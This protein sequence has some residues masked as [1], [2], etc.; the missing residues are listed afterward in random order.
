MEKSFF[1]IAVTAAF[2][3][4]VAMGCGS[5]KQGV[6]SAGN[7]QTV[8]KSGGSPF[9]EVY[10]APCA[11]FDTDDEFAATGIASGSKNRMDV[12]QTSAITN[13]QNVI[14]QKVQHAYKG[15]I[16]DYSNYMGA[17]AGSDAEVKVERAGTQIIDLMINETRATCGPKFSSVDERGD[18]TCF[19]GVKISKKQLANA[20]TDHV[21]K[22]KE[23]KIR[24]N[25][26]EFR[27]RMDENFKKFKENGEQ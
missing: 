17:N 24:F 19:V 10:E 25:E 22:D 13:A 4:I 23:L 5:S 21:S 14:R 20:I 2:A 27:K 6:Q 18:V 26:Q 3:A 12:L 16:D 9:G 11:A 15:A 1:K 7:N 8:A